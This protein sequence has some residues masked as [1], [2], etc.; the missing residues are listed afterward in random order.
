MQ[1]GPSTVMPVGKIVPYV[2][3][4]I[5]VLYIH[6]ITYI[7]NLVTSRTT[8]FILSILQPLYNKEK[9]QQWTVGYLPHGLPK[10]RVLPS[11]SLHKEVDA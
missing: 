5:Y 9:L 4:H 11:G 1:I 10:F 3:W 2:T 6:H 8:S 7:F